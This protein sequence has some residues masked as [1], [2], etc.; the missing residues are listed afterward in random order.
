MMTPV[1]RLRA[2][3]R[4]CR[5]TRRLFTEAGT[6]QEADEVCDSRD[7][8]CD[9]DTDEDDAIDA[10]TRYRDLDGDSYG[11]PDE[12]VTSC[13]ASGL[14]LDASDCDDTDPAISPEGVEVCDGADNDCNG[15]A[16]EAS[17]IDAMTFY[18]D[19]DGDG[20]GDPDSM[21]VSCGADGLTSDASDCDDDNPFSTHVAIDADCDGAITLEDCDDGDAESTIVATDGDCDGALT[22][23]D[24]DD[25]DPSSTLVSMD[26]DCDGILSF[27]DCDDADPEST[28]RATDGDCDGTVTEL[29]CDDGDAGS[30]TIPTDADCDGVVTA[31]DCNDSDPAST[32]VFTDED[33]DGIL[34]EDECDFADSGSERFDYTGA[35][36]VWVVPEC[37]TEVT[38]SA[39]GAGGKKASSTSSS[40][41][42][43]GEAV[44][45]LAVEPGEELYVFT[46]G[47]DGYNG[48]GPSWSGSSQVCNGG[49]GSDVRVGGMGVEDRV[50]VGGGGGVSGESGWGDGGDGGG[51]SCGSNCGGEG[52]DGYGSGVSDGGTRAG[53]GPRVPGAGGGGGFT[54]GGG[55]AYASA[56]SGATAGTGTLGP[57]GLGLDR[58]RADA[59]DLGAAGGGGGY[60]GGGGWLAAAAW[61]R[62]G[63]WLLVDR[64]PPARASAQASTPV[65]DTS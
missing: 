18:V 36:Q 41:G 3:I 42:R 44:G 2:A 35:Y 12:P 34:D 9:G 31:D 23:D 29:D 16:D 28:T 56:Y 43:G 38:I 8:D 21:E 54:S 58:A 33:C 65:R 53:A 45:T 52:G 14:V 37:V 39:V 4:V 30:T 62:R 59:A 32:T 55:G 27:G 13:G 26:G 49:G 1:S 48:G 5:C 50:I 63:R 60:W 25:G 22:A 47:T 51:G 11:D 17:A 20:Y 19:G 46:G 6:N 61:R 7:N 24:C 57:A 64:D 40:A 15:V 10:I